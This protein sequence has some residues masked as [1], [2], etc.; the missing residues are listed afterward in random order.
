MKTLILILQLVPAII[1]AVKA[2]EAFIPLPGQ[3]KNKLDFV[4]GVIQDTY[5]DA[6]SII[7]IIT[8]VIARVVSLANITGIFTTSQS[9]GG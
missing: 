6:A 1:E 9:A 8:K 3:G 4:L 5:A 2:A 7:P